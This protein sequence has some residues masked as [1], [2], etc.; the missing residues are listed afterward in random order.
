MNTRHDTTELLDEATC[1]E[2]LDGAAVGRLAVD[3]AGQ[4]DIFPVNYVVDRRAI[5]FRTSAG[6]KL[7]AAVLMR[8]VAFEID[9][10][11]PVDRSVWSVVVKGFAAEVERLSDYMAAEDLP[12]YPWLATVKPSFVR[13]EP[14]AVT[15]RRFHVADE[16]SPDC[17]IGW[18]PVATVDPGVRPAPGTEFHPGAPMMRPD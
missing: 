5:V 14:R 7:A 8:H 9:G 2:L 12:L 15:G 4:P 6:T 13:I 16:V 17:S 18:A 10:Y 1:W 11:E 3:V